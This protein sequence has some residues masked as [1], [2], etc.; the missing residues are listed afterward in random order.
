MLEGGLSFRQIGAEDEFVDDAHDRRVTTSSPRTLFDDDRYSG[1]DLPKNWFSWR[2]LW[3]FMGPG[4]L[5]SIAYLDPGNLESQLQAG[6][7]S[8]Y[9][10]IW[11]L[12]WVII[13]G[14]LMQ[15]LAVK[16]GVATG[17]NL[18]QQCRKVY[19]VFP[20]YILW[21]MMEIAIIGSDIQEVVGSAIA[22][23]LL[24]YGA[25]PLWAGVL[26]T[27][28]ASFMLLLLERWGV[29]N[30]EAL[31]AVLIG[32]MAVSFG[33][34]Y[35][36]AGGTGVAGLLVPR[37]P[38][39]ALKMAVAIVGAGI[40]PANFYLHS[41]L[42]HS[43]K[44]DA[45]QNVRKKEALA[46]YRIESAVALFCALLI[47]IC[48][49]A[50]FARGFY[51]T[52]GVEIGL[53]NA[54]A[55]LGETFGASMRIIWAIGL[56]AAGQSS[57]ITGVYTGQ[58]VMSGF[59]N[60]RIS[61]W[62]RI[63]ITRSVALVPTLL[64]SLLYRQP[65]GTELDI[66]N[67]WLNVLQSVQIPFA[68]LPLLMLTSSQVIMGPCF[69]NRISMK[70]AAWAITAAILTINGSLLYEFAVKELPT[71]WAARIGFL[72]SVLFY[73]G[74]VGYFAVGPQR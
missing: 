60:L 22:I 32:V 51:G 69:A 19:P 27:A 48:V 74:L 55:Y 25:V 54:G 39:S 67:E 2:K 30:L 11:V 17:L 7:N 18:A 37:L 31:F 24:T 3:L 1:D 68:L 58:F 44:I 13:M 64:V 15:M 21:I 45:G 34:M 57:T 35:I 8:G 12:M 56:L 14:Y 73:V 36:L 70:A 9:T 26:I 62:K 61:Q 52:E 65:G 29:R 71:H 50:V 33:V 42:V 6:A 40:M 4:F 43:R 28:V 20:R 49:V 16:L 72:G 10:L 5:M 59:L 38:R 63:S 47:N 66:L 46:Y 41:A 53:E 23:S